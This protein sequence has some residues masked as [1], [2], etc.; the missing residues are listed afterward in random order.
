MSNNPICVALDTADLEQARALARSL[1][2]HVGY[3]K[4][5]LEFFCAHGAAGYRAIAEAG[6]PIFL[7]LKLHDIPNTVAAA[8]RSLML[9]EP[10]PEI[11]N[12][13]AAGGRDMMV[14]AL[15]AVGG[16]ADLVAVTLLTSLSDQDV[17]DIGFDAVRNAGT[18]AMAL[19]SLAHGCGL[20]GIVCSPRDVA[21][22]R[23]AEG[24]GFL[25]IVPGI[26][27]MNAPSQD[28][29]RAATP[30]AALD[31]GADILVIGRSITQAAD[32][33]GA[34]ADILAGL[35]GDD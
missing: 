20:D 12:V 17:K 1:A 22:I 24:A 7:D 2:G 33:I 8:L 31:A 23:Q 15:E 19:A 5:G 18:H 29:K 6:T 21:A 4:L 27:L 9:L 26:R 35:N 34:A 28:Q 13:H 16:R 3:F 30:R 11:V 25:A 32:P 14:A 10:V